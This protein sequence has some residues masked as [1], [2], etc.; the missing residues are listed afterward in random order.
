MATPKKLKCE[1][2][3]SAC[4]TVIKHAGKVFCCGTCKK[5]YVDKHGHNVCEFC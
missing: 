4:K 1:N 3:G 5:K 2:C